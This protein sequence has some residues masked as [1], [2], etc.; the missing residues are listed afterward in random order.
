MKRI[1]RAKFDD[2]LLKEDKHGNLLISMDNNYKKMMDKYSVQFSQD[3]EIR[4]Y[5][6]EDGSYCYD[7]EVNDNIEFF[8]ANYGIENE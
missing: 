8:G 2:M 5:V 3:P 4:H 1:S 7:I 6:D